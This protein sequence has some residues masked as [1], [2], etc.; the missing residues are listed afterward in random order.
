MTSK[1]E[2]VVV[3][4]TAEIKQWRENRDHYSVENDSEKSDRIT[5]CGCREERNAQQREKGEEKVETERNS[6][7]PRVWTERIEKRLYSSR[8]SI[9]ACTG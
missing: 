5:R 3:V 4:A 1:T 2:S 6:Q 7:Y 9:P 8:I